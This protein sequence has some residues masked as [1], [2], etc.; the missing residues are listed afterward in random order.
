LTVTGDGF[1]GTGPMNFELRDGDP[2]DLAEGRLYTPEAAR[3][4]CGAL[5]SVRS[6]SRLRQ[7]KPRTV[8]GGNQLAAASLEA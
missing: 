2:V 6:V 1:N 4:E 7:V 8:A 3:G 5:G